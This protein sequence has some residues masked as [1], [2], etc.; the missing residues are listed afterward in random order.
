MS[1]IIK[2]NNVNKSFK[3]YPVLNDVNLEIEQGKTIGIIGANG[4][5]KSVLF[6]LIAGFIKPDSGEIFI[7]GKKI[8]NSFDFPENTGVLINEPGYISVYSGFKNLQ[9]LAKINNKINDEKIRDT[10]LAVGLDPTNTSKVGTY[11]MGM[12]KKLGI[13]QAI[14]E[15]QN[16]IIL[17]EPF[18]ALDFKSYKNILDIIRNEQ[19]K[20]HTILLTSHNQA[21]IEELC[22]ESYIILDTKLQKITEK[23]K[24][25][26]L[27]R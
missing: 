3:G 14:M 16:I 10:M 4:S 26:Y 11:S 5:G 15:D 18:N 27:Q 20:G 19:L 1:N 21:D 2:L 7:R 25:E 24:K 23:L 22:D 17:D 9:F 6:K 12:K 8:G 13:A